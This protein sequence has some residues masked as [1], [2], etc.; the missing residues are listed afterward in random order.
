MSTSTALRDL[1]LELGEES[2]N[3]GA[4]ARNHPF[5]QYVSV[6]VDALDKALVMLG[7]SGTDAFHGIMLNTYGLMREDVALRPGEYMSALK[8]MLDTSGAAIEKYILKEVN[9]RMMIQARSIEEATSLLKDT[10]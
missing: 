4:H 5:P 7:R 10:M 2:T 1:V 8:A 3:S 6:L 9:R